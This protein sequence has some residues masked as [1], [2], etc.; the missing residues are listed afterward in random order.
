MNIRMN[1]M[2]NAEDPS[3]GAAAHNRPQEKKKELVCS[4]VRA[5]T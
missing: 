2:E 5:S 4:S 1:I 3:A